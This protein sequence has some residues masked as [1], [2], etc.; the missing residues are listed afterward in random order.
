MAAVKGEH[1]FGLG[2]VG[3]EVAPALWQRTSWIRSGKTRKRKMALFGF[4]VVRRK[5]ALV[6][7]RET[8]LIG[9]RNARNAK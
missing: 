9:S 6:M 3:R 4:R 2:V 1:Q 8:S 5:I 7:R